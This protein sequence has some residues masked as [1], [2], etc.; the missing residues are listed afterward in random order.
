MDTTAM[1]GTWKPAAH[2][3]QADTGYETEQPSVHSV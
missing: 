2:E 1:T 3:I